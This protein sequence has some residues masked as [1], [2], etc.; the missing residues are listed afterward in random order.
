MAL[1]PPFGPFYH[2]EKR[3]GFGVTFQFG[4]AFL[5]LYPQYGIVTVGIYH[6]IGYA[7]LL[8]QGQSVN[9]AEKF[10]DVIGA[11]YWAEVEHGITRLQVDTLVFHRSGVARTSRIHRPR[12]GFYL[13]GQRQHGVGAVRWRVNELRC[14]AYILSGTSMPNSCMPLLMVLA[15]FFANAKRSVLASALSALRML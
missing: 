12:V 8:H 3:F 13:C 1:Q 14:H 2:L 7:S 10:A 9:N 6:L 5:F 15:T 4:F 11:V